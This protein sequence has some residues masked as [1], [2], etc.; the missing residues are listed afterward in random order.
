RRP[1]RS[2]AL[3]A[4]RPGTPVRSARRQ[5]PRNKSS[6]R[7]QLDTRSRRASVLPHASSAFQERERHPTEL[8]YSPSALSGRQ[9]RQDTCRRLRNHARQHIPGSLCSCVHPCRA[10]LAPS[11][12]HCRPC[13]SGCALDARF[14]ASHAGRVREHQR[15]RYAL[16]GL[17]VVRTARVSGLRRAIPRLCQP[18][19]PCVSET[20]GRSDAAVDAG[21]HQESTRTTTGRARHGLRTRDRHYYETLPRPR[22]HIPQFAQRHT[23]KLGPGSYCF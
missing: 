12:P 4:C 1:V 10:Y 8:V 7:V 2:S 6:T 23:G 9:S 21:I 14:Q 22:T 5:R 15:H 11:A 18:T 3:R 16:V 13:T 20:S 17:A 19:L